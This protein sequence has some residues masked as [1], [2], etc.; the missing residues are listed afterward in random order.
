MAKRLEISR[1][2]RIMQIENVSC[3]KSLDKLFDYFPSNAFPVNVRNRF[4]LPFNANQRFQKGVNN[5]SWLWLE[6]RQ[7]ARLET[8]QLFRDAEGRRGGPLW[9]AEPTYIFSN[10]F[11]ADTAKDRGQTT[12]VKGA[13]LKD[14]FTKRNDALSYVR[15]KRTPEWPVSFLHL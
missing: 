5:P 8:R 9:S 15:A 2:S 6:V 7:V 3:L 12:H 10:L 4:Y 13:F 1:R 11:R 14:E